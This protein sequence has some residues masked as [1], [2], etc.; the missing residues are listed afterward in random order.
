LCAAHVKPKVGRPYQIFRHPQT[1]P[2][3]ALRLDRLGNSSPGQYTGASPWTI[4]LYPAKLVYL[5]FCPSITVV[6]HLLLSFRSSVKTVIV[7]H[8]L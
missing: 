1:M 3:R 4:R 7:L 2:A 6:C 8:S 5:V